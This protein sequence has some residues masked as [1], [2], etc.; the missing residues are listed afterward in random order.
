[1]CTMLP[2]N[3]LISISA[4]WNYK[5]REVDH[6]TTDIIINQT[7]LVPLTYATFIPTATLPIPLPV[8]KPTYMQVAF[9]SYVS[10]GKGHP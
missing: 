9:P 2:W 6:N 3:F 7:T 1:M 10:I 5:F 8:I 4:F